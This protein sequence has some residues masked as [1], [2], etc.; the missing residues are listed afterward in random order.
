MSPFLCIPFAIA[1]ATLETSADGLA[2]DTRFE[3]ITNRHP[4]PSKMA[5]FQSSNTVEVGRITD[6]GTFLTRSAT[7]DTSFTVAATLRPRQNTIVIATG[8]DTEQTRSS[9]TVDTVSN[10]SFAID[11]GRQSPANRQA[12]IAETDDIAATRIV[13]ATQNQTSSIQFGVAMTR[14]RI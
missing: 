12:T 5:E 11:L 1:S 8:F 10:T 7:F 2:F 4:A 14:N 13:P 9:R 6:I 3:I